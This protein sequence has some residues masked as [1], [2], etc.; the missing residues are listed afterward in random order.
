MENFVKKLGLVFLMPFVVM[1]LPGFVAACILI[2]FRD[3]DEILVWEIG[4]IMFG[5][6]ATLAWTTFWTATFFQ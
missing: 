3:K 4:W 5:F 6:I 1:F 2:K